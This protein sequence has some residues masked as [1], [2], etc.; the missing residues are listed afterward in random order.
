MTHDRNAAAEHLAAVL[1]RENTALAALDLRR[2]AGMLTEKQTAAAAFAAGRPDVGAPPDHL[3][4]RLHDLAQENRMRLEHAIIV[5][6]R[7]I[8]II[9]GAIRGA[10]AAPRYGATGVMAAGQPAPLTLSARA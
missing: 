5:Q 9:A 4:R 6:R 1:A 10:S 2:A 3:A 7:I 8:G